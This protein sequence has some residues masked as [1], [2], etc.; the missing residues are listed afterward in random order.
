MTGDEEEKRKN[1]TVSGKKGEKMKE[2]DIVIVFKDEF[3]TQFMRNTGTFEK[4]KS[5]DSLSRITRN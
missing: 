5:D 1:T 3:K 4:F 2:R